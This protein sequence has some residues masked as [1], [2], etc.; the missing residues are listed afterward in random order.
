METLI[1]ELESKSQEA[2]VLKKKYDKLK[3]KTQKERHR[4]EEKRSAIEKEKEEIREKALKEAKSIMDSANKKIEEAVERIVEKGQKDSE[5]IKEARKDVEQFRDRVDTELEKIEDKQE[6]RYQDTLEKPKIGDKVRLEDANTTGEL[7]EI[8]GN[9][10]VI[11]AGGLRLKTKYK[12]LVKV[13]DASKKKKKQKVKVHFEDGNR[14]K[15]VKP[16]LNLRGMRGPEAIKELEHYLDNAIA[17]GRNE[18]QIIH[19]KGEGI[20]KKLVHEYLDKRN[21]VAGYEIAP[22]EQGGAGCTVVRL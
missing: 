13:E 12:K 5:T 18:V 3:E 8:N 1:S 16:E 2:E 4:Y 6:K 15:V 9:E 14:Y 20:L 7:E 19:G 17:A 22:I 11:L 21:E 10:A